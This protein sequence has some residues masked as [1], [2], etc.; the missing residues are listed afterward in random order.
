LNY[1]RVTMV[2]PIYFHGEVLNSLST[3]KR[4]NAIVS[5]NI[6]VVAPHE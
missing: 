1:W 6:T 4:A 3:T 5:F 2:A